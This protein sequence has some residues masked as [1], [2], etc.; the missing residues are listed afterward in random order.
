MLTQLIQDNRTEIRRHLYARDRVALRSVC[1]AL[2][3]EEA[4]APRTLPTHYLPAEWRAVDK[5]AAVAYQEREQLWRHL[6]HDRLD[7][8]HAMRT[9]QMALAYHDTRTNDNPNE[10]T[11]VLRIVWTAFDFSIHVHRKGYGKWECSIRIRCR[12]RRSGFNK[13]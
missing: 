12:W 7:E 11:R 1:R 8:V 3:Q 4:P 13:F 6:L 9:G 2:W 5:A 10:W